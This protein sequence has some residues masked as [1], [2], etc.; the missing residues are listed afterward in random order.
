M[1]I[2][3]VGAVFVLAAITPL[4]TRALGRNAGYLGAVALAAAAVAITVHAP[5]ILA[6][7]PVTDTLAWLPAVGLDLSLR[8]D[9]IGLL[10]ALIVLGIG[11]M[12]LAY[13]ARYFGADDRRKATRYLS[14]L[15]VFAGSMLGL[16]LADDLVLLFVFWELTSISSFF[17][18]GGLGEGKPGATRAFITTALGGLALLAGVLL[19]Q[20]TAGTSSIAAI[21]ADPSAVLASELLPVIVVLLLLAAFTKSAQAPFHFWL[22]GAMVAPTPVSTYLHAATMVKAGIYLLFRFTGVFATVPLWQI[23]LVLVGFGTSLFAAVVAI[24][25]TDLKRLLAYSTVSQL[26][27]LTG[28]IGIA[29]PLA[30]SAA[31]LHTLAHAMYK[32]AL[33]MTVGVVDHETGTRDIREL[34]GLRRTL[35]LTAA[36]G[37]LAAISM[38]GIPPLVGFVSK[39]EALAALVEG[40]TV[41]WLAPIGTVLLVLASIGT[42]AYSA[43]YYLRT[44][45]GRERTPA[46]HAP[47]SFEFPA[48]LLAI[49]GLGVGLVVPWLDPLVNGVAMAATGTDPDL[50]LALWH[51]FTTPLVLT[52][53]VIAVG[54]ALVVRRDAVETFQGRLSL[55]SNA[56]HFDRT[57]DAILRAGAWVG[58]SAGSNRPPAYL[59]PVIAVVLTVGVTASVG[60]DITG[61]PAPSLRADWAIVILLAASILGVAQAKSRLG[62]VANLGLAGFLVAGWFVLIGAPD[63]ALTQLLV[64]TL[65][66]ALVV[67]VFRRLPRVFTRGDVRRKTGAATFA[68]AV[69][70]LAAAATYALT[71]RR[72]ISEV[73]QRFLDEGQPLTG[74]NNIVNTILVDFRALDTLGEIAV[75]GTAA[76]GIYALVRLVR[77]GALPRPPRRPDERPEPAAD[78]AQPSSPDLDE[79]TARGEGTGWDG[80]RSIQEDLLLTEPPEI[81]GTIGSVVLRTANRVLAPVMVLVSFWLLVRGHDAVGGG[82]IGGLTG[83]S[84]VV[85]LY[86]SQGHERVWQSRILRIIPLVGIGLSI[87]IGYGLV[88]LVLTGAFLAGGKVTLP[89]GLEVAPS[90]IFDVGVYLVVVGII[91]AILRH[92][93]QGLPED[94][95]AAGRGGTVAPEPQ[96]VGSTRSA[97]P[98]TPDAPAPSPS[99]HRRGGDV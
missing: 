28:L 53:V 29:T 5:T 84:A 85:L 79:R 42:F 71:G 49:A 86:L 92:L 77:R 56:D 18:I 75:L 58:R 90:L 31:A 1:L 45:E 81:R 33:F 80:D 46:H 38:A 15:T 43:R 48:L 22:P 23:A 91:V 10:F 2:V 65:T 11:A 17:L 51:G 4:L 7:D 20:V 52:T 68:V 8:L 6:G 59:L 36:A 50:H 88:G 16:V 61:P 44:F 72:D 96:A 63:L 39:E 74:G 69:G 3:V 21:V 25:A 95:P 24:K 82:F 78:P 32:A 41:T 70:I 9:A 54:L 73:G 67:V 55:P 35:P 60:L 87:A 98:T 64:E 66:V 12:V 19:L 13:S 37:G 99:V 40:G 94:T 76:L 34:G 97:G 93:G 89:G 83:G 30:L 57:Y 27:L 14:L 26:G 62:A 47:A